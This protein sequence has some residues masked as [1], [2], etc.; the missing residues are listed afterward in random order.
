MSLRR[1]LVVFS[2]APHLNFLAPH[3]DFLSA[4]TTKSQKLGV[5]V[6]NRLAPHLHDPPSLCLV[7]IYIVLKIQNFLTFFLQIAIHTFLDTFIT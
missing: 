6:A 5:A 7:N 2:L 1:P 3:L 4:L